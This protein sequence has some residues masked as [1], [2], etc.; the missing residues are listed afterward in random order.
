VV[1]TE[2][3]QRLLFLG[4]QAHLY[5]SVKYDRTVQLC[6]SIEQRATREA[7]SGQAGIEDWSRRWDRL[8]HPNSVGTL[9]CVC[10]V[11]RSR[12]SRIVVR[13]D[14][15][16]V[17]GW[18]DRFPLRSGFRGGKAATSPVEVVGIAK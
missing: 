14:L 6:L 18:R 16:G 17:A 7:V 11:Y 12:R 8:N 9:A 13:Q 4:S 3:P 1:H 15:L 2:F 5:V 10:E